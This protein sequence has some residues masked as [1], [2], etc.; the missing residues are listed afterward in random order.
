MS[1]VAQQGESNAHQLSSDDTYGGIE[2]AFVLKAFF[3][4][5]LSSLGGELAPVV[6]YQPHHTGGH[7]WYRAG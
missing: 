6:C 5:E 3:L 1:V 4:E 2:G 7:I